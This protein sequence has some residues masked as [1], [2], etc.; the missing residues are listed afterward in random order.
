MTTTEGQ[1]PEEEQKPRATVMRAGR[2]VRY[3]SYETKRR[4]VEET[5]QPGSSVSVVARQNDVNANLVFFWRKLYRQERLGKGNGD[6]S[7]T[8]VGVVGGRGSLPARVDGS[9]GLIELE[10]PSGVRLRVD[11]RIEEAVLQRVLRAVKSCT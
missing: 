4:I 8:Q 7:F 11:S 6:Q 5:L 9:A 1:P 2:V 10:L 3:W